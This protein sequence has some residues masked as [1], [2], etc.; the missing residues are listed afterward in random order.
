MGLFSKFKKSLKPSEIQNEYAKLAF[1]VGDITAQIKRL[2]TDRNTALQQISSLEK[3]FQ[4]VS[5][6]AM[7]ERAK[8]AAKT[9]TNQPPAP[10]SPAHA[11]GTA[12]VTPSDKAV[13]AE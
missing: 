3:Q 12:E 1:Q 8:E 2:E 7:K 11:E 4:K 10:A 6:R 5:Q 13:G 9:A